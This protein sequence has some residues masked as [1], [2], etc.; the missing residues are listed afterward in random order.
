MQAVLSVDQKNRKALEYYEAAM[1]AARGGSIEDLKYYLA[2]AEKLE[3]EI[4]EEMRRSKNERQSQR[5]IL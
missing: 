4:D 5:G 1:E 3:H 2:K